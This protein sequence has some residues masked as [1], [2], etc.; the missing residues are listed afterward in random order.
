MSFEIEAKF[1][2]VDVN[3]LRKKIKE[4]GGKRIHKMVMYT[5]YVFDLLNS[6]EKG[7]I[8][9]RNENGQIAIT[10]KKRL[11]NSKFPLEYE[12][13][14]APGSTIEEARDFLIAQGYK[15]SAY[16]ET[17]REKWTLKGCPEIA[18]DTQPGIPTYVELECKNEAEIKKI[19]KL[20]GLDMKDAKYG[21]YSKLY[22]SYYNIDIVDNPKYSVLTFKD[23]DKQLNPIGKEKKDFL[24]KMKKENLK[25][26]KTNKIKI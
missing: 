1:L 23:V 9:T 3:S 24:V 22:M 10:L 11:P 8:R 26:I 19:S 13:L 21:G 7:Y 14:L 6:N 20:L 25:L 18:I 5:R 4:L 2:E 12:I 15:V 16:Q 17:L